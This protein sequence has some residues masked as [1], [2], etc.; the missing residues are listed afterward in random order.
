MSLILYRAMCKDEAR[1]TIVD[2]RPHF[3]S[4]YKWFSPLLEFVR[5]RVQGGGFN[6]SKFKPGRYTELL[7]FAFSSDSLSHF[8]IEN[9]RE[10]RM[11]RRTSMIKC[12]KVSIC[13]D[14]ELG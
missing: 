9:E 10:Y 3:V 6:N 11:D 14:P 7:E 1:R 5:D 13:E 8:T 4:R 2:N 12:E